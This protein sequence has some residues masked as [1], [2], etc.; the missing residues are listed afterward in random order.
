MENQMETSKTLCSVCEFRYI[1]NKDNDLDWKCTD[2]R[3]YQ[4]QER[5]DQMENKKEEPQNL[6]EALNKTISVQNELISFLKAEV[7]RLKVT[8]NT[9]QNIPG[10]NIP[11]VNPIPMQVPYNPNFIYPNPPFITTC[12]N[13]TIT[14]PSSTTAFTK[15]Y[16]CPTATSTTDHIYFTQTPDLN[17][18]SLTSVQ[19]HYPS[20]SGSG[21]TQP[22]DPSIIDQLTKSA[23]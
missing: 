18:S 22:L 3:L 14:S 23:R 21:Q 6:T 8:I 19:P 20:L 7:E 1:Y 16:V 15:G 9:Y 12:D 11:Q 17:K 10:T 5:K 4:S 2:C 13:M